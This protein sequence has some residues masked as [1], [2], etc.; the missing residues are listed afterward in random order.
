MVRVRDLGFNF[1]FG[2]R[3]SG[4]GF[5][6]L[7]FKMRDKKLPKLYANDITKITEISL[8]I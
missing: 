6:N 1:G 8:Y 4:F 2:V 3:G 7:G 5:R